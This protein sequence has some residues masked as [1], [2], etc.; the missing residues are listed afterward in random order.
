MITL[1]TN[2]FDILKIQ[3]ELDLKLNG[4]K[5]LKSKVILTELANAVFTVGGKAFIKAIN[6]EAKIKPKSFH[7]LY[8]WNEVGSN[9]ARLF[10][11]Y[12]ES[13]VNGTLIIKP[14]FIQ[15]RT[16]VPISPQLLAPGRTGKSVIKRSV[17]RDKASIMENGTPIIYRVSK[18][19]PI[20]DGSNINFIAAG[21][22][23]SIDHPGGIEVKGSFEKFFNMWFQT[24]VQSVIQS[25]GMLKA[26][27]LEVAKVLNNKGAGAKEVRNAVSMLLRQYSK[28][29]Y[30]L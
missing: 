12:K 29:E 11:I 22:L 10:F 9:S 28:D 13:A 26:I 2:K 14:G 5:E 8:E 21:T 18:N 27:D 16:N 30:V 3:S 7:H 1:S 20:P 4:I 23:I 17:F 24:K 25:S 19:T 6:T 15:S